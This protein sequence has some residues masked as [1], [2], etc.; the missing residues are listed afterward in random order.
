M[1][2][3]VSC[4]HSAGYLST[5]FLVWC[6]VLCYV[7]SVIFFATTG[8]K[9]ARN[10]VRKHFS[11][12]WLFS[13]VKLTCSTRSFFIPD[14]LVAR[15][16]VCRMVDQGSIPCLGAFLFF[17]LLLRLLKCCILC[18]LVILEGRYE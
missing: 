12:R 2:E 11:K 17:L 3:L 16:T 7:F 15:I 18:P 9:Y 1:F 4:N 10:H 14:S 6:C 8:K 5:A 13:F